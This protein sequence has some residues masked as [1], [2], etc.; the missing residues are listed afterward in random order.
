MK[1]AIIEIVLSLAVATSAAGQ[2]RPVADCSDLSTLDFKN[3]TVTVT[4]RTF[5]FHYGKATNSDS[6]GD[7]KP[8]WEATIEKDSMVSPAPGV[9]TRFLLIDDSHVTGTGSWLY[10]VG[11]RCEPT[12]SRLHAGYLQRVFESK[13]LSLSVERL[14]GRSVV[15]STQPFPGKPTKKHFSYKWKSG[16]G[17]FVL[18]RTWITKGAQQPSQHAQHDCRPGQY[19]INGTVLRGQ[20][21][22]RKFGG[23]QFALVPGEFGWG[24]DISQG[25]QHSLEGMTGPQHFV[26]RAI[27]IEGW[28]FRNAANTALN[29][30]DVNAP[31]ETRTFL[32]SPRSPYCK[33][34]VG[35]EEDGKGVLEVTDMELGNLTPGAT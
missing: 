20:T 13:A 8:D 19:R 27:D 16:T 33:D 23:L 30:G 35:L 29:T 7:E 32:F 11:F 1:H 21:F 22:S 5:A 3:L 10:L 14:D 25:E 2:N 34:A 31:D 9:E 26:P 18:R 24:I 28:H 4:G 12:N 15:V 6:P 17:K